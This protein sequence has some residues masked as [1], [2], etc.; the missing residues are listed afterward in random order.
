[1]IKPSNRIELKWCSSIFL[2]EIDKLFSNYADFN[3][4]DFFADIIERKI[5]TLFEHQK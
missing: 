1:M 4:S 3:L 5:L 2:N